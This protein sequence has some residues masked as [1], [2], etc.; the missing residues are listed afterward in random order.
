MYR[1]NESIA[2]LLRENLHGLFKSMPF[3]YESR[4]NLSIKFI[5]KIDIP[6]TTAI[7]RLTCLP[8]V[9]L[10]NLARPLGQIF[11]GNLNGGKRESSQLKIYAISFYKEMFST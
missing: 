6:W 8:D 2:K 11:K 4:K 1:S 7:T 5:T 3:D 9:W 10:G